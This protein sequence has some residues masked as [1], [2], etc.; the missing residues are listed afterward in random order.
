VVEADGKRS[1][2]PLA[3]HARVQ[4]LTAVFLLLLVSV[5]VSAQVAF[6]ERDAARV[7][8]HQR[9]DPARAAV[10]EL[11]RGTT[12]QS[13]SL[14]GYLLTRDLAFLE[15]YEVGVERTGRAA[16]QL[17]HVIGDDPEFVE[18]LMATLDAARSR[19]DIAVQKLALASAGRFD[20]AAVLVADARGGGAAFRD[21]AD[22]LR[23]TISEA[24]RAGTQRSLAAEDRLSRL[25][26]GTVVAGVVLTLLMTWLLR[27]WVTAPFTAIG[28]AVDRVTDGELHH[29]VPAV[30]PPDL[31]ALAGNVDRMRSRMVGLLD[32][33]VSAKEALEQQAPAVVTLRAELA[34]T[35]GAVPA[36]VTMAA[37]HRAAEGI[38]AGDWYDCVDLDDGRVGLLVVDVAGH[39]PIAGVF[40]LRA[41]HLLLAALSDGLEPGEALSWLAKHIGDTGEQFLTALVVDVD[42][43]DGTVRWSNAGHPPG[44]V[45]DGE[46]VERLEATG[47]LLGPLPGDWGTRRT[48]LA[49]GASVVVF[50][51][52]IL[53]ARAGDEEFG[54]QRLLAVLQA[55]QRDPG[56]MVTA[57]TMAVQAFADDRLCDD[58]TL[59][60]LQRN[61]GIP[62]PHLNPR[63]SRSP[64]RPS[65]LGTPMPPTVET[66]DDTPDTADA[67]ERTGAVRWPTGTWG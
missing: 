25:I 32:E 41:K 55:E 27:R 36:T 48:T 7:D 33:S 47:P 19:H 61:L 53:E 4:A 49:R 1:S 67:L 2:W 59:V 28:A 60:A 29:Q 13:T 10:N 12:E 56:R 17:E 38:L 62:P 35:G 37:S 22:A 6:S 44:V 65:R 14:R 58:I 66:I 52:G 15:L 45:L 63:R 43:A 23:Q 16:R 18:P 42:T 26:S 51:D 9:L 40:A 30:G 39:G 5:A 3:L 54:D 8:L 46:R 34:P 64:R 31:A 11:V 21:A 57:A 50:T 24:Q 20:E